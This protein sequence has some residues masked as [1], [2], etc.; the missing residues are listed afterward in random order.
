VR[1]S[2]AEDSIENIDT[3]VVENAKKCIKLLR[4]NIQEIQTTVRRLNIRFTLKEDSKNSKCKGTVNI[5]KNRTTE[6]EPDPKSIL[7]PADHRL[8]SPG[9]S[10]ET[11]TVT[12]VIIKHSFASFL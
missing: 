3:T 10:M 5:L 9:L 12:M 8:A 7:V 1:I 4:Q 11:P 2:G 6:P